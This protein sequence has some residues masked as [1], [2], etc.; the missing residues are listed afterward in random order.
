MSRQAPREDETGMILVN[1]LMMVA[2]AS[3]LVLLMI[4]REELAL[5]RATRLRQASRAMAIARG[6]ELSAIVAL[7]RD[8]QVAPDADYA[9]EPWG[10]VAESGA[11]IAGGSFDL[12]IGD[13][14]GKFNINLLMD[15]RADAVMLFRAI[16]AV[17]GL[18][19]EQLVQVTALVRLHGPVTDLR[20]L[21]LAGLDAKVADR[22]EQMVTALPGQTA[23][24]LNAADPA[25]LEVLFRDPMVV[26]RLVQARQRQGYIAL[27]DLSDNQVTQ[28]PGTS[29]RSGTFW[30]RTRATIGE[31]SQQLATLIQR[32]G[33]GQ[34]AQAVPIAR[35]RNA[36]VP[37]GLPEFGSQQR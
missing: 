27:K 10:K 35:W 24:N 25:T 28:P 14:E 19:D 29:F 18:S 4:N 1:V 9:T 11:Q 16:G 31:T 6:G 3:G 22:L 8:A 13:A 12:A 32:R 37:P 17:A 20:P 30:V 15:G 2:I 5:D 21:R 23:I 36:A 7:R 26:E 33:T 34:D